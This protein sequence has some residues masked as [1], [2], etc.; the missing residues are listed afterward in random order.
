MLETLIMHLLAAFQMPEF[1]HYSE[2]L[3]LCSSDVLLALGCQ[4]EVH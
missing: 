3:E 1:P 2:T 4:S